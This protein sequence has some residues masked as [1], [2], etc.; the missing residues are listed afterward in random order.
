M[1]YTKNRKARK[2]FVG[3]RLDKIDGVNIFYSVPV[4]K[5]EKKGSK[6]TI[7]RHMGDAKTRID[8]SGAEVFQLRRI[9]DQ[10]R[11]LMLNF[12]PMNVNTKRK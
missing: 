3:R 1:F 7:V 11:D 8:L 5:T 9:L 2:F 10:G 6:L 12:L 4:S